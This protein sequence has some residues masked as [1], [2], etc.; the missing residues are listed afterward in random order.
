MTHC[1]SLVPNYKL[2]CNET[3]T[4]TGFGKS[5]CGPVDNSFWLYNVLGDLFSTQTMKQPQTLGLKQWGC[6]LD[7]SRSVIAP[8]CLQAALTL[9]GITFLGLMLLE[10]AVH[11]RKQ[12][13]EICSNVEPGE[14]LQ[15][16]Y[17]KC[18]LCGKCH[19]ICLIAVQFCPAAHPLHLNRT[20]LCLVRRLQMHSFSTNFHTE[21]F[22]I[23]ESHCV[24]M[25]FWLSG[26]L[27]VTKAYIT[28][29]FI[30]VLHNPG[31][32]NSTPCMEK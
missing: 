27:P 29:L 21:V 25:K 12:S 15:N 13:Q 19:F 2:C 20:S 31:Y 17:G 1:P 30:I 8:T 28:S 23:W 3:H 10:E 6:G 5:W 11:K 16:L 14:L 22:N 7:E 24:N 4:A 9:L 18:M 32:W 26:S